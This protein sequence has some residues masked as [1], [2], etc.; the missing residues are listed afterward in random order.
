[1]HEEH[2]IKVSESNKSLVRLLFDN[3]LTNDSIKEFSDVLRQRHP[4]SCTES[5]H[6]A[7]LSVFSR[8]DSDRVSLSCFM[9]S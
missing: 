8:K 3:L 4:S 7:I 6:A 2:D 5:W 9:I 1:M